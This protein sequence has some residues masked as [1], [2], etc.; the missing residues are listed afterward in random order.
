VKI[1]HFSDLH[2]SH[3]VKSPWQ[4]LS[5]TWIGNANLL[6]TRGKKLQPIDPCHLIP[7]L[8]IIKP[9]LCLITGDLST[10][11]QPQEFLAAK[12]FVDELKKAGFNVLC[13][14]GNHDCYTK[15]AHKKKLFYNYLSNT[16]GS[17]SLNK[18]GFELYEYEDSYLLLFDL[19]LPTPWFTAYGV[20]SSSLRAALKKQLDLLNTDKTLVCAGHF[21]IL[22]E[23]GFCH[24]LKQGRELFE[25][26]K[27]FKKTYYLHGHHHNFAVIKQ[28][29]FIQIDAGSL[30]DIQKGSFSVLETSKESITSYLRK[31]D[32]FIKAE[33]I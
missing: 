15:K 21:P 13:L 24:N 28:G 23:G 6:L 7:L 11:A 22:K 26:F 1:V 18:E 20:A 16:Q 32:T 25:L 9:D 17:Q 4:F 5:K 30:S 2:F 27:P 19:A 29:P 8:K 12:S 31:G 3:F 10:T 33:H 14:P